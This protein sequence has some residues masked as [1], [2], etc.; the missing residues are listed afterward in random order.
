MRKMRKLI[1]A[2]RERDPRVRVVVIDLDKIE[3][4]NT[5][6]KRLLLFREIHVKSLFPLLELILDGLD[7]R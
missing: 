2:K 6:S 3:C 7:S 1:Q 5:E 4:K